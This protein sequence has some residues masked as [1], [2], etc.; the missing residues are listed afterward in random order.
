MNGDLSGA[1]ANC[2]LPIAILPIARYSMPIHYTIDAV[3]RTVE[4]TCS[5]QVTAQE[6]VEHRR[7]LRADPQFNAD[8]AALIDASHVDGFGVSW[9][10][11]NGLKY[12]DPFSGKSRRAVLAPGNFA[13]GLGRMY[14]GLRHD[15][16][17]AV[18]RTVDAARRWIHFGIKP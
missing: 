13:F 3:R 10:L 5:G 16:N 14:Q 1:L 17:F 18:F 7:K 15:S 8:F 2:Y 9:E 4:I 6:I 12:D 11:L